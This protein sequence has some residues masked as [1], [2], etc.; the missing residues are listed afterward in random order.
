MKKL[1]SILGWVVVMSSLLLSGC[2]K[3][4]VKETDGKN[5]EV[6]KKEEV[7]YVQTEPVGTMN[8]TNKLSLPGNLKPK[9]E[10]VVTAEVNGKV[11]GIYADLGKKVNQ[12]DSL[13][14]LD[15]TTYVLEHENKSKGISMANREYDNLSNDYEKTKILYEN[16]VKSKQAFDVIEKEYQN[17]KEDLEIKK[18]D[19][20]LAKKKI[21]DTN[22]K[23]PISGIVSNKQVLMGQMVSGGAELFKL[24]NI[25]E[26]YVEVGVAE[27]DMPFIKKG[28]ECIVKVDIFSNT[29][30]GKITNIGPEPSNE[31]K[32]YPVKILINNKE[33]KL[34]SGMFSTVEIILDNHKDALAVP[35]KAIIKEENQQYIFLEVNKRAVKKAVKIGFSSDEYYEIL[36][37]VK[38]DENVIIVGNDQLEDGKLVEVK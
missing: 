36:E 5:I 33:G 27:K 6:E 32:T 26:M 30:K 11:K 25:D 22:I 16:K 19:L 2:G 12:G 9:E 3:G 13:C 20:V 17:K 31:T 38:K 7:I 10:A 1:L 8:F 18:N 15:D 14:K 4:E 23:A 35:K 24:I 37:G 28:Q 34:K 29:F 21:D